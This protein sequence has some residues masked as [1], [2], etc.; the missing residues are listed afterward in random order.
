MVEVLADPSLYGFTG[1]EA[2]AAET[3][4]ARYER[5]A[6]GASADGSEVWANW[7]VRRR[8]DGAA[9]GYVQAGVGA[10]GADLAW[11]IG[12]PWQ[13]R[14]FAGEAAAALA[15]FLCEQGVARLTAHVHP[16][17]EASRRVAAR[18]GL[19]RTGEL[20]EDGEE[21]W[22]NGYQASSYFR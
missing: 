20:A 3:L 5:Q 21:V 9:V 17:H 1:G 7:I 11:V 22:S 4:R 8:D 16:R 14:G 13:G 19:Q 12:T 6:A 18:A 15:A 2:P 10:A